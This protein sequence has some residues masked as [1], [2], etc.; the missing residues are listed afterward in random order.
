[1]GWKEGLLRSPSGV[2]A[3]PPGMLFIADR[4][5]NRV[6]VFGVSE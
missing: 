6:A 4:G 5:N 2:A 3:G 1:M